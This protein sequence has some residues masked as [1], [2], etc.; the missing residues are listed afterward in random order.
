MPNSD[1]KEFKPEKPIESKSGGLLGRAKPSARVSARPSEALQMLAEHTGQE[2][3][4]FPYA[5]ALVP[6]P[7]GMI[8]VLLTDVRALDAGPPDHLRKN[9]SVEKRRDALRRICR[10]ATRRTMK[11]HTGWKK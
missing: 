1:S 6:A 10:G 3:G 9:L 4:V 7:G 2:P 8:P 11:S 5:Y